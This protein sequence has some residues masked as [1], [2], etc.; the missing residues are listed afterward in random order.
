MKNIKIALAGNPNSG[1]T[2]LFNVLTGARQY[3]GNWPG[4]TVEKKEG[5]L[6]GDKD[7]VI[8]DL[9]G[10]YS[11]SPYSLEE[12]ITRQYLVKEKPDVI[13]N[14]VDASNLE[15]NLYLTTQLME[16]GVPVVVALNMMDVIRKNKL[17]IDLQKLSKK[18]N[19]PV[20][21]TSAL[22][23]EGVMKAAEVAVELGR[24]QNK[25]VNTLCNFVGP[26][27]HQ[28]AHIESHLEGKVNQTFIRW[29][30][31][32][33][34]ERDPKILEEL[35]LTQNDI[36]EIEVH[37]KELEAEFGEDSV[38][39]IIG[40][41][42]DYISSLLED[43]IDKRKF[44]FNM[45]TISDK[46]D[47]VLTNRILALPIFALLMYLVYYISMQTVGSFLTDY[48]NETIV[49]A[50]QGFVKT[51]LENGGASEILVGLIVDGI[52]AG[53]G[54]VLGFVPQM[55]V[56]YFMLAF[57]EQCGYMSRVAFIM[58]KLFRK[59]GLSGKSFIPMLV[60][61]G[62]S[63]P[64]IMASRTIENERDRRMTIM[65][66]SFIPCSAKMPIVGLIAAAVFGGNAIIATSAYFIGVAAV[67]VS[68]VILKKTRAFAGEPAEFVMEL[69][70]YH[71][72]K[73]SDILRTTWDRGWSFIKRAGTIILLSSILIWFLSSFGF[74]ENGFG[75][76][77]EM[78]HSILANIGSA[79]IFMF[80]PI[81]FTSWESVVATFMGLVAKEEV[82]TV[83]GTLS[84]VGAEAATEFVEAGGAEAVEGL[85]VI[86]RQFFGGS[87]IV[88]YSFLL[89][90]L[91]CAPCFAAI[92]AI[93]REMNNAKWAIG[94]ILYMTVFA[95]IVSFIY[96]HLATWITLGTFGISTIIA[97]LISAFMLYMLFRKN[98]YKNNGV[99]KGGL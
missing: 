70:S 95:W 54:A 42:Y 33:V 71:L 92:G 6:K 93:A 67:V 13:L 82:V 91:L 47:E 62:C 98:P 65:T 44:H 80:R 45:D 78:D 55:L 38:S 25:T 73:L 23:G 17:K 3:V 41:R 49:P 90:N 37:T 51:A 59:F 75:T 68:G 24:S 61:T 5:K 11:L 34:F 87:G 94:S 84:S 26:V 60:A 52:I 76:V 36:D 57:L 7:V 18:L 72:P 15:R 63:V 69:P 40:Q 46:I 58:D 79:L 83:F 14:V 88:A 56:L 9:P 22:N 35:K 19:C 30:A 96:Y 32:K 20:I 16:L 97:L 48:A 29:Y 43:V 53:V 12:V 39:L 81:G 2:T 89:F 1:K 74:T 27:E 4:V 31:V 66:T 8:Q 28:L 86:G 21:E 64:G 77:E 10:I 50:V 99:V 85:S